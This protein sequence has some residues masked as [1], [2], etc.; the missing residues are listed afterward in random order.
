VRLL[1]FSVFVAVGFNALAIQCPSPKEGNPAIGPQVDIKECH[2]GQIYSGKAPA[3]DFSVKIV[4]CKQVADGKAYKEVLIVKN[5]PVSSPWECQMGG[6]DGT[7]DEPMDGFDN[8]AE[9]QKCSNSVMSALRSDNDFNKLEMKYT[10]E[11]PTDRM[12]MGASNRS[13]TRQELL[14]QFD[15]AGTVK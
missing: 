2:L 9:G 15:S 8:S 4:N 14:K 3:C 10:E 1:L 12:S 13:P 5:T 6:L 7:G 11:G